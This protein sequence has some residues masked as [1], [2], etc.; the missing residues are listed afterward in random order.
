MNKEEI[1][2]Y[3]KNIV[4]KEN[5]TFT[6]INSEKESSEINKFKIEDYRNTFSEKLFIR[7]I[8]KN[9]IGE[10]NLQILNKENIQKGI[11]KAKEIARIKKSEVKF[12][13]F[14]KDVSNKKIKFDKKIKEIEFSEILTDVKKNLTKEKYIT[15]YL[16]GISKIKL[17]S[18]VI[19]PYFEKEN[20]KSFINQGTLVLTKDKKR[21]SGE[22]TN[23]YTKK[24]DVK[25]SD[26]F[27]QAKINA[28]NLLNPKDGKKGEYTLIFT[29][30]VTKSFI[31]F[32]LAGTKGE[33][34]NKKTSFLYNYVNKKIFSKNL[35][36]KENPHLDFFLG[37]DFI[38]DEGFKTTKKDIFK[39]GVFKKPIYDLYSSIKYKK[40]PTGN[41]FLLNN[42]QAS[43]TNKIQEEGSKKINDEISKTKKGILIYE[44]LGFH[45]N[46]ITTGDFSLTISSGKIIE[47]GTFKKTITNLNF[48][49]NFKDILKDA[50]FSKEQKFFGNS[51]YSFTIIPNLK[52]F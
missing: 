37:S 42:Y 7:V 27:L 32:I 23:I 8:E 11:K 45:T 17:N 52:L 26:N 16:G 2:N 51:L 46:K 6:Y 14:G 43:Y 48:T 41:G 22:F 5:I 36:I 47:N 25:I 15:G 13:N 50:Y 38:D 44:L 33:E 28:Y 39:E 21:S 12:K 35:T 40:K 31:G 10:Y 3:C 9:N 29:P 49:G 24:E 4:K 34:I 19:N 18:F 20:E 30:E 1:Y